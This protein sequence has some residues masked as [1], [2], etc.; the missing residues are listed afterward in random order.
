MERVKE[1]SELPREPPEFIEPRPPASWPTSGLIKCEDLV[2][3]YA[4]RP[5]LLPSG[6]GPDERRVLLEQPELPNVL[7]H[8]SFEIRPGE[9]VGVLGRTGSGKS[10]LALSFFR[11]VEPTEGRILIDGLDISKIGLTDLRSKLTIIP[12]KFDPSGLPTTVTHL[13]LAFCRGPH[14]L[15]RD[16]PD[17]ARCLQ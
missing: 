11:F 17:N 3:R 1:F 4:V 9:K 2:I 16:A 6:M 8:L 15:E 10:T 13:R 7:H 12:R 14:H 5:L